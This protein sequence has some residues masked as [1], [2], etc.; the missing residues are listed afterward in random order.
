VAEQTE[1]AGNETILTPSPEKPGPSDSTA[2]APGTDKPQPQDTTAPDAGKDKPAT[3]DKPKGES[4]KP[5][6]KASQATADAVDYD[7]LDWPTDITR[8]DKAFGDFKAIAAELKLPALSAQKLL[9]LHVAQ[10]RAAAQAYADQAQEWR[11][12]VEADKQLG[13]DKFKETVA[14]ASRAVMLF[15]DKELREVLAE[16]GLG[17]HPALVRFADKIGRA[18]AEDTL[19]TSERGAPPSR[20]EMLRAQFPKSMEALGLN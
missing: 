2:P 8:D 19:L 12:A 6:E 1:T 14:N 17:N 11:A 9:D 18:H 20:D 5:E 15:G 13:G 3:T 4:D 10:Q 16:T 7:K